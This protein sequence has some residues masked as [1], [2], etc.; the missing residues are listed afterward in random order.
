MC[1]QSLQMNSLMAFLI[2]QVHKNIKQF[3]GDPNKITLAGESA[4]SWSVGIHLLLEKKE[5]ERQLFHN[6]IMMSGAPLP[7]GLMTEGSI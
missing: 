5:N 3:G 2:I 1:P 6:A 7:V 4:G